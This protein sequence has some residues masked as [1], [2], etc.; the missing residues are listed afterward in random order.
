MDRKNPIATIEAFK[1]AFNKDEKVELIIKTINGNLWPKQKKLLSNATL[2][3]RNIHI[4]DRYLDRSAVLRA[5]KDSL[6][7]VSLHRSEG[8]GLTLAESMELGTPVIATGYSGNMDFMDKTNSM[9]VDYDLIDVADSSGAYRIKS[10]WA[11]PSIESAAKYMRQLFVDPVFAGNLGN[12]GKSAVKDNFDLS[13]TAKFIH[14]R[15]GA[16]NSS[17]SPYALKRVIKTARKAISRWLPRKLKE[18][19]LNQSKL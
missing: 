10:R 7:Y 5:I 14:Q 4:I 9:M 6:A 17:T 1:R 16:L 8:Y 2:G 19:I 13:R 18:F 11:D 15:V 12:A 3:Y